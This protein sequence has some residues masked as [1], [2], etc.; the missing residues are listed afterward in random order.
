MSAENISN[1]ESSA[2]KTTQFHFIMFWMGQLFSLFGSSVVGYSIFIYFVDL[3]KGVAYQGTLFTTVS[4]VIAIPFTIMLFFTGPI[5]DRYDR[6]KIILIADSVQAFVTLILACLF[7]FGILT[8]DTVQLTIW[9]SAG[10]FLIRNVC[11]GFHGP[12]IQAIIP[13]M[14]KK[15]NISRFNGINT[16]VSSAVQIAAPILAGFIMS[17]FKLD[18][19]KMLWIDVF[20]FLFALIPTIF[21]KI[22][23]PKS[24]TE[25][26]PEK[27]ASYREEFKEGFR[28]IMGFRGFPAL[29]LIILVLNTLSAPFNQLAPLFWESVAGGSYITLMAYNG[30]FFQAAI[31]LG[32]GIMMI[33]KHWKRKS[34]LIIGSQYLGIFAWFFMAAAGF[35]PQYFWFIYIATAL[36]GLYASIYNT[37]YQTVFHETVPPEKLGRVFSVDFAISFFLGPIATLASGP[38]ADWLGGGEGIG[39]GLRNLYSGIAVI[40]L[41]FMTLMVFFSNY[42]HVGKDTLE[43][44][45]GE[46][47]INEGAIP[48]DEK[49]IEEKSVDSVEPV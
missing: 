17:V 3:T 15:E 41:V 47:K 26:E 4:A 49:E 32:G 31:L 40:A 37:T 7:I 12:S 18:F 27:K 9:V 1:G 2:N 22:P 46:L 35:F 25:A 5:I 33:R 43:K 44:Q 36:T 19:T 34:L 11:Q 39:I 14:I 16:F 28:T 13:L 23:S 24:K 42:R 29:F 6:K 30:I 38:L 8:N 20:T 21:I 48:A 10:M 45:L